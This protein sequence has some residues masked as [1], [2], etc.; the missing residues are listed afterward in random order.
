MTVYNYYHNT[1]YVL[2]SMFYKSN[3]CFHQLMCVISLYPIFI[4]PHKFLN[5][6]HLFLDN[7]CYNWISYFHQSPCV[8]SQHYT[9]ISTYVLTVYI[10]F[11]PIYV[12]Y[13]STSCFTSFFVS[14]S[15]YFYLF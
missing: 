3:S 5:D 12:D 11:S 9:F 7:M 13:Q 15:G 2:I 10:V 6:I 4:S 1:S 14:R 8:I